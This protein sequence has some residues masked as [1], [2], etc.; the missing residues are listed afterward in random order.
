MVCG[1]HGRDAEG[2]PEEEEKEAQEPELEQ[3]RVEH[4]HG[5]KHVGKQ[6]DRHMA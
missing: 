3:E 4:D 1:A 5:P 2:G 6:E